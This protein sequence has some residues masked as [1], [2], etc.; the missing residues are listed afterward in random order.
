MQI[1][2]MR[3]EKSK[4]RKL[5]KMKFGEQHQ[6]DDRNERR[7]RREAKSCDIYQSE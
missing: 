5:P 4:G 2:G 1:K 3:R 7:Q 6:K